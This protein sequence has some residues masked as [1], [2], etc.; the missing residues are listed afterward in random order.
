MVLLH[1][2]ITGSRQVQKIQHDLKLTHQ[3]L[4]LRKVIVNK[5]DNTAAPLG[6][7]IVL[8]MSGVTHG[9]EINSTERS[10]HLYIP[11]SDDQQY[12]QLDFHTRFG[13]SDIPSEF[14]IKVFK[15]DGVTSPAFLTGD[16]H[17]IS[18]DMFFEYET[19]D[20]IH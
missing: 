13:A 5:A 11:L 20:H 2:R 18:V 15:N 8:D 17:L 9:Y 6:G 3:N 14:M 1:V 12:T 7:G 4:T 16:H 19:N 10:G